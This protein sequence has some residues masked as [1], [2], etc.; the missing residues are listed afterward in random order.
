MQS[1]QSLIS[2]FKCGDKIKGFYLCKNFQIKISRLGD[3]YIDL[4]LEDSSGSIRAKIW[5]YVD[6]Y[7][8]VLKK[9]SHVA[10]KGK[11]IMFN[12]T[13]E[14]DISYINSIENNLYDK[15][16]YSKD[17]ILK[18]STKQISQLFDK[19]VYYIKFVDKKYAKYI[20]SLVN[21]NK[22]T[23]LVI[24]S[25]NSKYHFEGGYLVQLI[26]IL[27]LNH[28]IYSIY[29]YN[30]STSILGIILKFIGT[31]DYYNLDENFS[32]SEENFN[33]GYKLLGVKILEKYFPN[34][35]KTIDLIKNIIISNYEH[36]SLMINSI[37]NLYEFDANMNNL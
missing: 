9:N 5:S 12:E 13:L 36:E 33:I 35:G 19:L 18:Y 1:R 15:Y 10:T 27:H 17:L 26:S 25:V 22:S 28:K 11:V 23:I 4:I 30:Y 24:P 3:E 6:Q 21:D 2:Y 29:K 8:E 7:K 14:I 34:K 16:G 37:N 31:I 32:V 20:L